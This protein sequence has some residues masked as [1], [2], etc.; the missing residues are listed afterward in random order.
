MATPAEI[1]AKI[2]QARKKLEDEHAEVMQSLGNMWVAAEAVKAAGPTDNLHDLL[3]T[4]ESEAKAA[5]DGG[6]VGSG[7]ND[8]RRALKKYLDLLADQ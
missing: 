8:H 1:E 2:A 4:L 5:R 7:S 3:A 6:I